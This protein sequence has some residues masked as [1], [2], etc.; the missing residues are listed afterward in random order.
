M[1]RAIFRETREGPFAVEISGHAGFA[2]YGQDIVCASVT[3]ALQLAANGI[4][5][6]LRAP[7]RVDAAENRITV[8][9]DG[10]E[11]RCFLEALRLHLEILAEQFEN[12]LTVTVLEV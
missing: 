7:A 4:T 6:V 10:P 2:D 1:I 9:L 3:S 11:G 5:E 8:E 12:H